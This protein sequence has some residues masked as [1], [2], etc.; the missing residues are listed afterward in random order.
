MVLKPLAA[1]FGF[2]VAWNV[3]RWH[4]AHAVLS[5]V[6]TPGVV[7]QSM[8]PRPACPLVRGKV[9]VCWKV[10]PSHCVVVGWH[11]VQLVLNPAVVW[12][13]LVVC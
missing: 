10:A 12:F 8:Q 3:S 2:V 4:V 5:P 9:G 6:K 7:W 11:C 1:W 13:G